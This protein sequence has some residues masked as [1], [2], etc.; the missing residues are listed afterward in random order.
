MKSSAWFSGV[1]TGRTSKSRTDAAL[2]Y[3][4]LHRAVA[5]LGFDQRAPT[6]PATASLVSN[7]I[8]WLVNPPPPAPSVPCGSSRCTC[9]GFGQRASIIQAPDGKPV[10]QLYVDTGWMT[11]PEPDEYCPCRGLLPNVDRVLDSVRLLSDDVQRRQRSAL[12]VAKRVD[13]LVQR[14]AATVS[15]IIQRTDRSRRSRRIC[16]RSRSAPLRIRSAR[17]DNPSIRQQDW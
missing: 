17:A 3:S 13:V 7:R 1:R 11:L 15:D 10:E 14:E 5:E 8:D 6:I 12:N 4:T 9:L 16:A 2:P